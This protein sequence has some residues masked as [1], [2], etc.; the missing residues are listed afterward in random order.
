MSPGQQVGRLHTLAG[1]LVEQSQEPPRDRGRPGPR[2]SPAVA[3]R[4]RFPAARGPPRRS[5]AGCPRPAAARAATGHRASSRPRAVRRPAAPRARPRPA[6]CVQISPSVSRD[7]LGRD[8][9]EVIPLA[10]REHGD[11]NLVRLGGREEELDVRRRLLQRLQQGVEGPGREHVHF[12]DV[13][14]LVPRPAGPQR[15]RSAVAR[16][17]ARRRCCWP[18]RS[19]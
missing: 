9:G 2:E 11:R 7:R 19:R 17:P 12:V 5:A 14:N 4:W 15:R 18:R 3:R 16:A 8:A 1:A 10:A 6:R 13:V